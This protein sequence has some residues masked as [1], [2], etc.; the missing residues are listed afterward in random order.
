[1]RVCGVS[2]RCGSLYDSNSIYKM[3]YHCYNNMFT[4]TDTHTPHTHTHT[5]T[6]TRA[7]ARANTHTHKHTHTHKFLKKIA[8]KY[9]DNVRMTGYRPINPYPA[10]V[11]KMVSS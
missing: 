8:D 10:N 6:H 7:R 11:E 5:H 3:H 4:H 1:M 2:L 9:G